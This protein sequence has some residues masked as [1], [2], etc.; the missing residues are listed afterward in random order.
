MKTRALHNRVE[1]NVL[2]DG[3]LGE[4]SYELEFPNGGHNVVV[5]NVIGQS[6]R[7][8]NPAILSIG[9]EA[10]LNAEGS[11]TV[12]HNT[13][14]NGAGDGGRFIHLWQERLPASIPVLLVNNLFAGPGQ[15]GM[16]DVAG[17]S[18]ASGNRRVELSAL[19]DAARG[20]FRLT[21][22]SPLHGSAVA[23]APPLTPR[24]E[25]LQPVGSRP[26]PTGPHRT[27]GA[28]QLAG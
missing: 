6:P 7:T 1:Y 22:A 13:L 26:L 27:P 15:L 2:D 25:P 11:L 17:A 9:A 24:A 18:D 5:G 16:P 20:D 28:L 21:A 23:L 14:V 19:R 10:P 3:P 8:Q 4:A 12:V